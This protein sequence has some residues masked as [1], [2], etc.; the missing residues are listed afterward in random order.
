MSGVCYTTV[1]LTRLEVDGFKSLRD[2]A[3][4][5]EP[6][7]VLIGPN[8]AGKSNI[9]EAIALLSR[10]ARLPTVNAL[11]QGR[12]LII[13][14]FT[15]QGATSVNKIRFGLETFGKRTES[16]AEPSERYTRV[17][18]EYSLSLQEGAAATRS[19][20]RAVVLA[21]ADDDWMRHHP[22]YAPWAVYDG[23]GE[24]DLDSPSPSPLLRKRL[25]RDFDVLSLHLTGLDTAQINLH[26]PN[27]RLPSE[28][29]ASPR[30][31][32]DASNLPAALAALP[33]PVLGEVRAALSAIIPGVATFAVVREGEMLSLEFTLVGGEKVPARIASDGTLRVLALLVAA[34]AP[35]GPK[36]IC[37]EEPENGIYPRRLRDLL[38]LLRDRTRAREGHP[39]PPQIIVTTHSPVAIGAL[40]RE[41]RCLR[42]V[43][44]VRHNGQRV[45]RVR[46]VGAGEEHS[47]ST[48][49]PQE[50]IELLD[51]GSPE[52]DA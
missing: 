47:R 46:R 18:A 1:V 31:A 6:F 19:E 14:Q 24:L 33:L 12:G 30:L 34:H 36:T 50:I 43:D 22:D 42:F 26:A 3:V 2:F 52:D 40:Q 32:A 38:Q 23:A 7:T 15:R 20:Q 37:I 5:L 25:T 51:V 13:D 4:D 11:Q 28:R 45:T 44:T 17:R 48:V 10:L 41:P 39:L 35:N 49:S 16:D 8:S 9:I 27:L 21:E 29:L